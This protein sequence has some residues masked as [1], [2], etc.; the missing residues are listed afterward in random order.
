MP[1]PSQD[2]SAPNHPIPQAAFEKSISALLM[3]VGKMQLS[4]G[5]IFLLS[6]VQPLATVS[7]SSA[8]TAVEFG[9]PPLFGF[10]N[11]YLILLLML[12]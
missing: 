1:L 10:V 2:W 7:S 3:T 5:G 8:D 9:K 6:P 11:M 4:P 12:W